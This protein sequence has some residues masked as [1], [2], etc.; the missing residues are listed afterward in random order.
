MAT[1]TDGST[2]D[3]VVDNETPVSKERK[4]DNSDDESTL[5]Q[6]Y[7]AASDRSDVVADGLSSSERD[8]PNKPWLCYRTLKP[9]ADRKPHLTGLFLTLFDFQ[10]D[11]LIIPCTLKVGSITLSAL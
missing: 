6:S 10:K 2:V 4:R 7:S 9:D 3:I 11:K 5:A 1:T 8:L